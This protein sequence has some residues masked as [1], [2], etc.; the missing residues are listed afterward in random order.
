MQV[1]RGRVEE[2]VRKPHTRMFLVKQTLTK[3]S[4]PFQLS[5]SVE[6]D[7]RIRGRRL[8]GLARQDASQVRGATDV[9]P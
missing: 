5:Q 9:G 7:A 4:L 6:N 3:H 2:R 8:R 1:D